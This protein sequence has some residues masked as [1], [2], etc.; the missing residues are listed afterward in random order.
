MKNLTITENLLEK[1]FTIHFRHSAGNLHI[2]VQGRFSDTCA[3]ELIKTIHRRYGGS[4]RVFIGTDRL[5]TVLPSGVALF[6]TTLTHKILPLASLY[7][8]G[9]QG[10]ALA[11]DG[12][13]VLVC[14]GQAGGRAPESTPRQTPFNAPGRSPRALCLC[15][16]SSTP[17]FPATLPQSRIPADQGPPGRGGPQPKRNPPT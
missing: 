4:G 11:P 3:W 14:G 5:E 9:K 7:L 16:R 13:R 2:E 15:R 17:G 1:T 8:K 12:A 6:K 10:F